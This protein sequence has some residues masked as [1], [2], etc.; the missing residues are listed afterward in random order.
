MGILFSLFSM[1][2]GLRFSGSPLITFTLYF[3]EFSKRQ[4]WLPSKTKTEY[5]QQFTLST[6]ISLRKSNSVMRPLELNKYL[7]KIRCQGQTVSKIETVHS[8]KNIKTS[9]KLGYFTYRVTRVAALRTSG[10]RPACPA[11]LEGVIGVRSLPMVWMTLLPQTHRP[12]QI[13]TPPYSSS[14]I[15]DASF[16]RTSPVL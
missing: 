10:T 12:I 7:R 2:E 11:Y 9:Y 15:G 3:E 14:H 8:N 13:P 6:P 5:A 16:E 1:F 4:S